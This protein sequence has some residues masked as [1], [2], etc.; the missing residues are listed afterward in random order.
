MCV[1]LCVCLCVCVRGCVCVSVGVCVCVCG[2]VG[3]W[4]CVCVCV[5][6]VCASKRV[7]YYDCNYMYMQYSQIKIYGV[8]HCSVNRNT[9]V[10]SLHTHT[11]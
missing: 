1:C 7:Q 11:R 4:V 6:C 8:N 10:S 2:W 9:T 5:L 3:G